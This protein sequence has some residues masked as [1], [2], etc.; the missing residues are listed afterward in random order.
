MA[1]PPVHARAGRQVILRAAGGERHSCKPA[2]GSV[3][4]RSGGRTA[5]GLAAR[6]RP[7]RPCLHATAPPWSTAR[8]ARRDSRRCA[9]FPSTTLSR[10]PA[11]SHPLPAIRPLR[12]VVSDE[13]WQ[14]RVDLAAAYRLVALFG[15]DDLVFTHISARVPGHEHDIP[16]QSLRPVLRGDHRVEPGQ[17][18]PPRP[19]G[20]GRPVP[21]QPGRLRDPQRRPRRAADGQLRAAHAHAARRGGVGAGRR[22]AAD[23][24]AVGLS[25]RQPRLPRLRGRGAARRREAAPRRRPRQRQ[26]PDPAQPRPAHLRPQRGRGVPV[27]VHPGGGLPHPDHGA[28]GRRAAAEGAAGRSSTTWATRRARSRKGLGANLVWPGLLRRLDRRSPG[29]DA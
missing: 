18:R 14:V 26:Q 1:G 13:E 3:R 28:V 5:V 17:G 21:G 12:S 25:A 29:Y 22:A 4:G 6:R 24:A 20:D 8:S 15:W 19:A 9:T 2:R 7:F 23:L 10:E 11:M 16:D 27:D